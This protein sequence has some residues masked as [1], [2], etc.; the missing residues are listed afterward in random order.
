MREVTGRFMWIT[1]GRVL[2][3]GLLGEPSVRRL[4]AWALYFSAGAPLRLAMGAQAD[5][6]PRWLEGRIALVPPYEPHRVASPLRRLPDLLIEPETLD[7]GRLDGAL[8]EVFQ[9]PAGM[10]PASQPGVAALLDRLCEADR[11]LA[12]RADPLPAGDAA[13]D[14]LVFGAPLPV[15][16][17]DPRI[18][19]TLAL[20]EAAGAATVSGEVLAE[21]VGLS[22]SRFLHLFK[23]EVGVPLRTFRS[24]KRA[25][26][27]LSHVTR[28]A[29][30]TDIAYSTGYPDSAHFSRSV[31]QVFGLQPKDVVAGCRRLAL[32]GE[33]P[34]PEPRG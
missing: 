14:R 26:S 18:R 5:A 1:P 8:A 16:A 13:F 10:L 28:D 11:H 21:A 12:A 6:Q 24:W 7:P 27:W 33:P 19:Q 32:H 22:F 2:Y 23:D 4:G 34:A 29:N 17:L 30:L 15:R 9:G 25:R 20:L 31:R 3:G